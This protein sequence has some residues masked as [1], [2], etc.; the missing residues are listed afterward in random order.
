MIFYKA[1]YGTRTRKLKDLVFPKLL[2][3]FD[4]I[5]VDS[6]SDYDIIV[7]NGL[8]SF[9]NEEGQRLHHWLEFEEFL[10]FVNDHLNQY[11]LNNNIKKQ[12][13]PIRSMWANKYEQFSFVKPHRHTHEDNI[14]SVVFYIEQP[15]KAGNFHICSPSDDIPEEYLIEIS[16]GDIVIFPSYYMHWSEPNLNKKE[17]IMIAI[18]FIKGEENV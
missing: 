18:D 12:N 8:C 10:T 11:C 17:K 7:N 3:L 2:K 13:L 16:E 5:K 9:Y 15:E 14:I 4:E 1:N 6:K